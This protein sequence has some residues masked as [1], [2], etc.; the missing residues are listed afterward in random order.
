MF[1]LYATVHFIATALQEA[2]GDLNEEAVIAEVYRA[3]GDK[4]NPQQIRQAYHEL[5]NRGWLA[6]EGKTE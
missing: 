3:K 6:Q 4:F 2:Y 5:L 1:E